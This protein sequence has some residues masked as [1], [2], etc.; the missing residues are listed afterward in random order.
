M[1]IRLS[2]MAE[3]TLAIAL[4]CSLRYQDDFSAALTASVNH[5]GDSDSTGEVTGNI[6]GALHGF[7]AIEDKWKKDLELSEVIMEMAEDLSK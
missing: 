1:E 3:E 2:W 7:E 4:Y 5:N 6:M